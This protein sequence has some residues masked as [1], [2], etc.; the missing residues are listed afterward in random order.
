MI[1]KMSLIFFL[2]LSFVD[3]AQ[4]EAPSGIQTALNINKPKNKGSGR[5]AFK[6]II[7]TTTIGKMMRKLSP[8][9]FNIRFNLDTFKNRK[10]KLSA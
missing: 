10:N 6:I 2:F 5:D 8:S 3:I 7:I 1:K 4:N 9:F